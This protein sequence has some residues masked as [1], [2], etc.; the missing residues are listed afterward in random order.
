MQIS[1]LRSSLTAP[2]S[3]LTKV[4]KAPSKIGLP[5]AGDIARV[6]SPLSGVIDRVGDTYEGAVESTRDLGGR[7][8]G[9][10]GAGVREGKELA[11]GAVDRA[12][13]L[14]DGLRGRLSDENSNKVDA[15]VRGLRGYLHIG[16]AGQDHISDSNRVLTPKNPVSNPDRHDDE[17]SVTSWNLH[18]SSSPGSTGSKPQL[19]VQIERLNEQNPDVVLLQEVNPW[20]AQALVD[21][22]GKKGYYTQTTGRQGNLILVDPELEV[23]GNHRTTLNHDIPEGDLLAGV[24]AAGAN[25]GGEPRVAQALRI[26]R[27]NSDQS[28]VVF[29]THLSTGNAT[30]EDRQKEQAK[31]KGFV[32]G[33]SGPG[34]AVIGG[35]DFNMTSGGDLLDGFRDSGYSV[36]GARIDFLASK[37]TTAGVVDSRVE[38]EASGLQISDHPIV[39]GHF[40]L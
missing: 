30:P 36:D 14:V 24:K 29:N 28:I 15:V 35:G 8:A 19:D 11:A 12:E 32:D 37:G 10:V 23:T 5:S 33:L 34:D 39:N 1:D 18:H 40:Q 13:G 31:F 7:L 21:G 4:A 27:P 20:D 9:G 16:S 25:G 22:T 38:T 26:A 2:R 3:L 17:L 6:A